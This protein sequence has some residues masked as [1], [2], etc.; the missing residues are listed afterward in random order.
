M[1]IST[2][3][4]LKNIE[5]LVRKKAMVLNFIDDLSSK[6]DSMEDKLAEYRND[7]NLI[8]N[9]LDSELKVLETLKLKESGIYD[10]VEAEEKIQEIQNELETYC[11]REK[12]KSE[13]QQ[14]S[15]GG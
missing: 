15:E 13:T 10:D 4:V 9:Q 11:L 2:E 14:V 12:E 6:L 8:N 1:P 3:K 7:Y 5:D